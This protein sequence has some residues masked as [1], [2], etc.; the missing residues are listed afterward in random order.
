MSLPSR[1]R[2]IANEIMFHRGSVVEKAVRSSAMDRV[3]ST[4]LRICRSSSRVIH[5]DRASCPTNSS[6]RSRRGSPESPDW[7][8]RSRL[9]PNPVVRN[10]VAGPV[11]S[12]DTLSVRVGSAPEHFPL[13]ERQ[14]ASRHA[15]LQTVC[16]NPDREPL[17]Q[18]PGGTKSR[19]S[20]RGRPPCLCAATGRKPAQ[21]RGRRGRRPRLQKACASPRSP[22]G[23]RPARSGK[24]R[25][26][27]Q[28]RSA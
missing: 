14:S 8:S 23:T 9:H 27:A 22:A 13:V 2:R 16:L 1:C 5:A 21:S 18:R 4:K 12:I 15:G 28:E 6:P 3:L 19:F 17:G 11:G 25:R 7:I 20:S 26:S 10:C 24:T